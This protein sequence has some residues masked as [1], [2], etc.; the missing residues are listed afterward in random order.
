MA[1]QDHDEIMTDT[2]AAEQVNASKVLPPEQPPPPKL[3]EEDVSPPNS[4]LAA[5]KHPRIASSPQ[6]PPLNRLA[7]AIASHLVSQSKVRRLVRLVQ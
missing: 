3:R 7:R 4:P 2:P 5:L 1:Q 6:S